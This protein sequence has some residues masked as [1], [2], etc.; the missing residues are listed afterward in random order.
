MEIKGKV[1]YNLGIQG[2]VSKSGKEW[3]KA[4]LIV[5]IPSQYPKNVALDNMKRADEFASLGVGTEGTFQ[6]EVESREYNGRWYTSVSCWDWKVSN[7]QP[8]QTAQV[9]EPQSTAEQ[10][11]TPALDSLG[12]KGY[13]GRFPEAPTEE[14]AEDLPF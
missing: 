11:A 12:V 14:I 8:E 7:S 5:E 9:L 10:S 1:V 3:K 6:I 2:G 4:S 13:Q